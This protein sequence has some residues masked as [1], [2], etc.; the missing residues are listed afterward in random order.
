MANLRYPALSNSEVNEEKRYTA[1]AGKGLIVK[2]VATLAPW[3]K[4]TPFGKTWVL[5]IHCKVTAAKSASTGYYSLQSSTNGSLQGGRRRANWSM[6]A[7]WRCTWGTSL[8][9]ERE[10][11]SKNAGTGIV[12]HPQLSPMP[13]SVDAAAVVGH[14]SVHSWPRWAASWMLMQNNVCFFKC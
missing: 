14:R 13:L 7:R 1:I 4:I 6:E 2:V 9:S 8:M 10:N 12:G 3:H 5:R 11:I